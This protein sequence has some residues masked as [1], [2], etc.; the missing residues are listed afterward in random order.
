MWAASAMAIFCCS[1]S[2]SAR[3][4]AAAACTSGTRQQCEATPEHV[5]LGVEN[6][7][8][9]TWNRPITLSLTP[10]ARSDWIYALILVCFTRFRNKS[11]SG[12][13]FRLVRFSTADW[14]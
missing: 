6:D 13:V 10:R 9:G 1:A 5:L 2:L 7:G 8:N 3:A 14:T 12:C 4:S 11:Q